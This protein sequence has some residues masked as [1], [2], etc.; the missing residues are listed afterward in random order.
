MGLKKELKTIKKD[1]KIIE[2]DITNE[3]KYAEK[4]MHER[5]KFF[6][7]LA[8]VVGLVAVLLIISE[9]YF[10]VNAFG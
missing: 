8:W 4:W 1:I 3:L 7:K 5:K 10:R 6:I 9:L 2:K